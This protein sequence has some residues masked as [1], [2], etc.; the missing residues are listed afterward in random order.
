MGQVIRVVQRTGNFHDYQGFG[1]FG[2]GTF[3]PG[4]K[5][6]PVEV[7]LGEATITAVEGD[8]VTLSRAL[9]EGDVAFLGDATWLAGA[10][11]FAYAR[12]L[13]DAAGREMVPHFRAT[14][15]R[16]DNRLLPHQ[17]F[18]STHRFR[19]VCPDPEVTARAIHRP[20]PMWL[21]AERGWPVRDILMTE[22]RR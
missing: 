16:S 1:P 7:V 19:T 4:Q 6:L 22:V 8:A 11:G 14:D 2:D 21:A 17:R 9:P 13:V 18:T 10:P 3:G 20:F 15:V 5:G 12:V